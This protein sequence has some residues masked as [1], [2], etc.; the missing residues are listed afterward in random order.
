MSVNGVASSLYPFGAASV[1]EAPER[2]DALVSAIVGA[3]ELTGA[4]AGS[5]FLLSGDHRSLVVAASCGT[6]PSLLSGW[7]RIPV[8]SGLPAAEAYRSGRMIH[9]SG[10]FRP[11]RVP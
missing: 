1:G 4:H 8:N 10:S 3:V 11:L 7:R 6:P 5:V 2:D 9:P